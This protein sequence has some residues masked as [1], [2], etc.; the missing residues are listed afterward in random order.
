M[1]KKRKKQHQWGDIFWQR[2]SLGQHRETMVQ[3]GQVCVSCWQWG[4]VMSHR[5]CL[6]WSHKW[7]MGSSWGL[8]LYGK[9][10]EQEERFGETIREGASVAVGTLAYC[11]CQYS[12]TTAKGSDCD[13]EAVWSSE[14]NYVCHGCLIT[15]TETKLVCPTQQWKRF[16]SSISQQALII[17]NVWRF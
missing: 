8:T 6:F 16:C 4:V 14:V 7:V 15:A 10:R 12:V 2:F 11:R 1:G 13:I 3:G 5:K 17:L 9:D